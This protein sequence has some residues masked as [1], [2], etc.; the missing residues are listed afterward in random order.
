MATPP[1][2]WPHAMTALSTHD[3]KRGEDV[4]ARITVLAEMPDAWARGARPAAR[5]GARCPT[6]AS[7][8]CCGRR[9]SAPGR[10]IAPTRERLHGYAEKAMR[11]AGDRTTWT[12]P[13]EAYEAAVHAAVDA[14]FDDAEVRAVLDGRARRRRR[15][16]LEQRAGR[17]AGRAHD[18]GRARRLP[19]QR[20]VGAEPRRPRQ[21]PPGR[22]RRTRARCS[23]RSRRRAP[24]ADRGSTTPARPSCCVTRAG[25]ARCAATGPSCSRPTRRSPPTGEAADHVLAF[26][27]GGAI[28][29]ATRLPVGLAARGGW[30]DTVARPA[31]RASGP[32]R[33][34]GASFT[35]RRSRSADLLGD[36][37]GRAAGARPDRRRGRGRFD[38]WAPRRRVA[39]RSAVGD[40][41]GAD[42]AAATT[43]GGP[44]PGPV[45]RRRGRLRLP[46][47]RRHDAAAR[48][49]VAAPARR[50]AR[51]VAHLRPG[52]ARLD[53][54]RLDRAPARRA[55]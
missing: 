52:G 24:G 21:P 31:R 13:D 25:A 8:T 55:R 1:G 33:S 36:L 38:V 10:P 42:G 16:R 50:R 26:D 12:E 53:G 45:P 49:A 46:P 15:R 11:E 9:S 30:G 51:A 29:V 34:P 27:R 54:R 43:A 22:L 23:T 4:R 40:A 17:Q 32:T 2:D 28:T 39:A 19:G 48:P 41:R 3:T 18:A 6:R 7:A 47:R 44:P 37:P 20:A 35:G 5:A 14:A